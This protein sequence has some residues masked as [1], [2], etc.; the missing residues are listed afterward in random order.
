MNIYNEYDELSRHLPV[1]DKKAEEIEDGSLD[2]YCVV[3]A[4]K[5]KG[6]SEVPYIEIEVLAAYAEDCAVC[7]RKRVD[8]LNEEFPDCVIFVLPMTEYV[9]MQANQY[10]IKYNS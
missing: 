6:F 1:I 3:M 5:V 4:T 10:Q 2:N 7:T 9:L 8:K